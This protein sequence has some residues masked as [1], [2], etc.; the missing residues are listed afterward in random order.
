MMTGRDATPAPETT[1][2]DPRRLR[3]RLGLTIADFCEI[4][5]FGPGDLAAWES[6]SAVPDRAARRRLAEIADDPAAAMTSC[7][8]KLNK[9]ASCKPNIHL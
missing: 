6:G 7:I 9:T 5:R 3:R 8:E 1:A 2:I 4:Y